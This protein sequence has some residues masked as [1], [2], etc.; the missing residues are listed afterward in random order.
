MVRDQW[1]LEATGPGELNWILVRDLMPA[2]E[3]A[4][5]AAVLDPV[6]SARRGARLATAHGFLELALSC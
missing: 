4:E 6:L 1:T 3:S 2:T 5:A